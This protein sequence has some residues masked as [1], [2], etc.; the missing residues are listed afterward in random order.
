MPNLMNSKHFVSKMNLVNHI[1]AIC[2]QK[3]WL[4]D[5]DN[6]TMFILENYE[7]LFL[8]QKNCCEHVGVII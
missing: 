4:G 8:Q 6:I 7:M 5:A 2:L 3:C 1:S